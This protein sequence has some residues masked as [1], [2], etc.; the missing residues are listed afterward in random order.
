MPDP[1]KYGQLPADVKIFLDIQ[2]EIM[3]QTYLKHKA[4]TKQ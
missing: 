1:K 3:W 4:E 2:F